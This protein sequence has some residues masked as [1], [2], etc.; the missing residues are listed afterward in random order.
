M[1]RSIILLTVLFVSVVSVSANTFQVNNNE[2]AYTIVYSDFEAYTMVKAT[3]ECINTLRRLYSE[4]RISK[5]ALI[6]RTETAIK[7]LKT[8]KGIRVF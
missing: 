1:L 6:E 5:Q 7:N 3:V 2:K 4:Q 8:V